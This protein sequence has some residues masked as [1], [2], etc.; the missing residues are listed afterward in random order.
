[1]PNNNLYLNK[2]L[3]EQ[4]NNLCRI[5]YES[6]LISEALRLIPSLE[7]PN[8]YLGAG[9]ISQTVWNSLSDKEEPGYGIKD[10]DLVYFD[11][12]DVSYEG[13]DKY[14]QKAKE[15]FKT[16]PPEEETKNP[17]RVHMW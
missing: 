13:E 1:M 7:L 12:K 14:I 5:L 11:D 17:A 2:P 16:F 6:E 10:F 9:C 15:I 8:W 3:E 4:I